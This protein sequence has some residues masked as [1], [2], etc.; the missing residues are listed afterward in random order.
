MSTYLALRV[1]SMPVLLSLL[2]IQGQ[3]WGHSYFPA[4]FY[5]YWSVYVASAITLFFVCIEIFRSAISSF[6]GLLRLGTVVFRWAA[7]VSLIV[8][9]TSVSFAKPSALLITEMSYSLMRSVSI[10]ELCLLGFLCLSMNA[11]RLSPR[12]LSFGLALG[13]G[14]MSA[15]DFIVGALLAGNS[16][17]T[18]PLQ[19]LN[20]SL[21]LVSLIIWVS[22][23]ALPEP[24]RAP[25]TMPANSTIYRWNE[26]AAALGHGTQ[27][28]MQQPANSF[29]LSDV[30]KVV[31]KVLTRNLQ[32]AESK[33]EV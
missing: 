28:A 16:S 5:A 27:V 21:I 24:A 20:E 4:Y 17:L 30:E 11:L 23:V 8:S 3:S 12:D 18:S 31:D 10:L 9:L 32:S 14:L 1:V 6:K 25:V 15:N 19:F 2:Y 13:F 26:I 22:Y 29:F 7:L 33:S